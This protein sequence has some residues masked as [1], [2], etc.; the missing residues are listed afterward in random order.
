MA[1]IKSAAKYGA[2]VANYA[3]M[4]DFIFSS[5]TRIAGVA[6]RD[7]ITNKRLKIFGELTVN[8]GGPWADIILGLAQKKTP[9]E[10]LRRSE[11]IHIITRKLVNDHI[12]GCIT[13]DGKH[14][15]IIPW[16]GHSL[17]GTTDKEYIGRPDD[18]HVTAESIQSLLDE[19]NATFGDG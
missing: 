1:F 15:F 4:E 3:E 14:L 17:I 18:Y 2:R 5:G 19:I 7:K 12:V 11:G 6:V 9:G 16:R 10:H 13:P 8:C